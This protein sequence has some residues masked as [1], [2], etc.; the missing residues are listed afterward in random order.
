MQ[1][2]RKFSYESVPHLFI[3]QIYLGACELLG[4]VRTPHMIQTPVIK[5]GKKAIYATPTLTN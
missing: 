3:Q 4:A 1:L 2:L 5:I